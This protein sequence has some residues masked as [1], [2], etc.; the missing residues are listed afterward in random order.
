ME[1]NKSQDNKEETFY[2]LKADNTYQNE[3]FSESSEST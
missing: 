3:I 2:N 1:N